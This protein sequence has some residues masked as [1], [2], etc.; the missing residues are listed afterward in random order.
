MRLVPTAEEWLEALTAQGH[1]QAIARENAIREGRPM[2][3][4][5][6]KLDGVVQALVVKMIGV[7]TSAALAC[8]AAGIST[9][10]FRNWMRLGRLDAEAENYETSYAQ[11]FLSI[12]EASARGELF[13]LERIRAASAEPKQWKAAAWLLEMNNRK[14]YGKRLAI[15]AAMPSEF[16]VD[17][18]TPELP[19][20]ERDHGQ[21]LDMSSL[22][23]IEAMVP[24]DFESVLMRD[25][26]TG[27]P[28]DADRPAVEGPVAGPGTTGQPTTP[29]AERSV[30]YGPVS[31]PK[32]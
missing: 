31:R 24:K 32:Q 7:G 18:E 23:E 30:P 6:P 12:E 27:E 4:R 3:R 2:P 13:L 25:P 9:T 1:A 20:Q 10:S 22:E 5:E 16:D 28:E 11:F 15:S 17:M 26:A 14:R 21:D 29:A 8:R 19:Y